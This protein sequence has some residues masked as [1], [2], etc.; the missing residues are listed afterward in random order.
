MQLYPNFKGA[1]LTLVHNE[2]NNFAILMAKSNSDKPFKKNV[3]LF[4]GGK[5]NDNEVPYETA[6][7]EF[8]EHY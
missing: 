5:K 3:W 4:P 1:G 6:Y 2:N 8:L 7:R